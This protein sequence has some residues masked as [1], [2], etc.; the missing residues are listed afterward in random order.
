MLNVAKVIRGH[1]N[2]SGYT[3][4]HVD[5]MFAIGTSARGLVSE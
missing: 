4:S 2:Y 3:C 5:K 1:V